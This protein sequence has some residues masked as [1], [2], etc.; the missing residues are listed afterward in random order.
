MSKL[1]QF[2]N[3]QTK[4][5]EINH[6]WEND[7][8]IT[9][10][11]KEENGFSIIIEEFKDEIVL[12]LDN[13][14]HEHYEITSNESHIEIYTDIFGFVRDLLANNMRIKVIYRNENPIKW[15][16]EYY[17]NNKWQ[18]S[19]TMGIISLNIFTKKV[20]KIYINNILPTREFN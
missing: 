20:E 14:Y 11:K 17:K 16:I 18:E 19:S 10:L 8:K 9:F 1:K 3:N 5:L 7:N 6:K 12:E 4:I 13:G 2:L 15:I